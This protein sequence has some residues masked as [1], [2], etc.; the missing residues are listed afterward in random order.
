MKILHPLGIEGELSITNSEYAARFDLSPVS[1]GHILIM[2]ENNES[3]YHMVSLSGTNEFLGEMESLIKTQFP[4]MSLLVYE[5]TLALGTKSKTGRVMFGLREYTDW[6][7]VEWMDQGLSKFRVP[8]KLVDK[9]GNPE[10]FSS[11]IQPRTELD[12][13]HYNERLQII[14]KRKDVPC[15][16]ERAL[17]FQLEQTGFIPNE[18]YTVFDYMGK[19]VVLNM[20][21]DRKPQSETKEIIQC[22]LREKK[23]IERPIYT[24]SEQLR[25]DHPKALILHEPLTFCNTSL[26]KN[27]GACLPNLYEE[28]YAASIATPDIDMPSLN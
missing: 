13:I 15:S 21:I 16:A 18:L 24:V 11:R 27:A 7:M 1:L 3:L 19:A 5:D 28:Y 10:L 12:W 2:S 23:I 20:Y 6:L 4:L 8:F 9:T 26:D 17:A 14:G 22:K 25:T